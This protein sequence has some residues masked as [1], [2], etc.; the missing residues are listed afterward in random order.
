MSPATPAITELLY[1]SRDPAWAPW[2]VQYFF[3]IGLSYAAF[4][5]SLP[6]VAFG[7]TSWRGFSRAA[8]LGALVCGL[9]APVAL[10][11]DLHQPGRFLNFYLRPNPTSWMAWGAFF[12]PAYVGL[13]LL[14]AWA[15]LAPDLAAQAAAGGPLAPIRR[16][17]GG[18][19]RPGLVRALGLVTLAAAALVALYTGVEVMIVQARPLWNTA[20]L[21]VQFVATA[22]AGATGLALLLARV[23]CGLGT[24][25]DRLG[26]GVLAAALAAVAVLGAI[27]FAL[28][29]GLTGSSEARALAQVAG[30]DAWRTSALWLAAAVVVPFLVAVV[31]P[32]GSGWLTGLVALNAAWMLRWTVFVGGQEMPKTGAGLYHHPLAIGPE[33]LTGIVG[34]AGLAVVALVVL[35]TLVAWGPADAGRPET[36]RP[37]AAALPSRA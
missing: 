10:L 26:N 4:A 29:L 24:T 21:P 18:R 9:V 30:S 2:A 31:R 27:W 3:L 20:L 17:L 19:A 13:L 36:T 37:D 25:A 11:S 33:G 35:T 6:G 32:V 12:I 1:V 8:L 23:A 15:A 14:Y 22:V 5:L 28:A 7:R 16:L 34:T